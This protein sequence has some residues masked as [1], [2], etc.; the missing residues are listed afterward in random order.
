MRRRIIIAESSPSVQRLFE[1]LFPEPDYELKRCTSGDELL[2]AL[3]DNCPDALVLSLSLP[4]EDVYELVAKI[5]SKPEFEGLPIF[6]LKNAFEPID[7]IRLASLDYTSL[8]SKPFDSER[9]ADLI[10]QVLGGPEEPLS[11]PEELEEDKE[12]DKMISKDEFSRKT[13]PYF[14]KSE[15]WLSFI[16]PIIRQEILSLERELEKRITASLRNELK[17]WLEASISRLKGKKER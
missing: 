14:L 3:N 9:V 17:S 16:K 6:L 2:M 5:N 7:E 4:G 12:E 8:I 1:M 15:D 10:K 11:L 13:V